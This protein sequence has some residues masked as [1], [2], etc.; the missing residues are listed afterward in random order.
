MKEHFDFHNRHHSARDNG[1]AYPG[2]LL[3]VPI[4]CSYFRRRCL[5]KW[6]S[7]WLVVC[8]RKREA[9]PTQPHNQLSQPPNVLPPKWR[10]DKLLHLQRRICT[11]HLEPIRLRQLNRSNSP[12]H[13]PAFPASPALCGS[14]DSPLTSSLTSPLTSLWENAAIH[15]NFQ[16][17]FSMMPVECIVCGAGINKARSSPEWMGRFRAS[18][19]QTCRSVDYPCPVVSSPNL[20]RSLHCRFWM[21]CGSL[22]R[23]GRDYR[24]RYVRHPV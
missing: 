14:G 13:R 19:S 18:T 8:I 1:G 21:G 9:C 24:Q 3:C 6:L 5:T 23:G 22:V 12:P 17:A 7:G 11:K 16:F 10:A 20:H 4:T 2:V 15:L